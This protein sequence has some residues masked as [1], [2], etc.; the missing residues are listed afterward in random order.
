MQGS[1]ISPKLFNFYLDDAL[2]SQETLREAITRGDLKAFADGILI[3]TSN[4]SG[5]QNA[6][7]A[8]MRL[9]E[10]YGLTL[11]KYRTET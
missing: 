9:E 1:K 7:K 4:K 2:K 10:E 6:A 3:H 8:L 5:I 11:N